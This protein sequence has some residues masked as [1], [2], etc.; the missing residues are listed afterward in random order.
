MEQ[1]ICSYPSGGASAPRKRVARPAKRAET[2]AEAAPAR[3]STRTA[4]LPREDEVVTAAKPIRAKSPRGKAPQRE[5][6]RGEEAPAELADALELPGETKP[7]TP[8]G[9]DLASAGPTNT[10]GVIALADFEDL[11]T[12]FQTPLINFVF[13]LVG[14]RE[15]AYDLTQDVFVK[16][17]AR[18]LRRDDHPGGG[19]VIVALSHR[20][21]YRD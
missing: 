7:A 13:R 4:T 6:Q 11:F 18:S 17:Y 12:R 16:A 1:T 14:N 20:V 5:T 19:V 10:G 8:N 21:E 2:R 15:Q 3:K 9:A